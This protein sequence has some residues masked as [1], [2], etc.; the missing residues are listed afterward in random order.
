[1]SDSMQRPR[2]SAGVRFSVVLASGNLQFPYCR[3]CDTVQYPPTEI[4][5]QCLSDVIEIIPCDVSGSVI[6]STRIYRSYALDFAKGGPWSVASVKMDVGPIVFAHVLDSL[7]LATSVTLVSLIDA[8]GDGVI[9]AITN[10][11]DVT[12]L[13]ARL[14]K[15][16]G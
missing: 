11:E 7:V 16:D 5:R 10:E 2:S 13:Q 15:F 3:N 1:M 9:G 14:T 8:A 4:C 12:I 6:A